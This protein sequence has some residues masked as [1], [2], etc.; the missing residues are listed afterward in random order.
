MIMMM[1]AMW[2]LIHG[3][4]ELTGLATEELFHPEEKKTVAGPAA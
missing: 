2:R 1:L 3:L 4:K